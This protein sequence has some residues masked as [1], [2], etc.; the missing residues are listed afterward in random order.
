[1]YDFV[2]ILLAEHGLDVFG[3]Q[4]LDSGDVRA[5]VVDEPAGDFAAG[6]IENA[7]GGSDAELAVDCMQLFSRIVIGVLTRRA[8]NKAVQMA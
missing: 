4:A 1:M 5:A 3:F 7:D 2:K 8:L 6:E